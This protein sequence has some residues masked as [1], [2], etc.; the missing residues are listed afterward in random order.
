M[1]TK[2]LTFN[3]SSDDIVELIRQIELKLIGYLRSCLLL[4][5]S[6]QPMHLS[7]SVSVE[8]WAGTS[9]LNIVSRK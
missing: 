2:M 9:L 1:L 4:D 6:G 5:I 3:V 8:Y 7:V